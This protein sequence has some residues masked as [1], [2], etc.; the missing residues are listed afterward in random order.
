MAQTFPNY[1]SQYLNDPAKELFSD[2]T[3]NRFAQE[4]ENAFAVEYPCILSRL[5]LSVTV[6][7]SKYSIPDSITSIRRVTW[8]GYKLD[9]LPERAKRDCFQNATQIGRPFWY[10][11]NNVGLNKIQFF[12]I[13]DETIVASQVGLYDDA[14]IR[15]QVIVEYFQA[16]DFSTKIIPAY[17]RRRLLK[18]YALRGCFNIEGQGQSL[19]NAKYWKAK[20]IFLKERYGLLLAELHNK[21]RKLVVNSITASYYFPGSPILPIDRFGTSVNTGE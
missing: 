20:W 6:N 3:I 11:F 14:G 12:P 21:P 4:G 5:A 16:P 9:P 2:S 19:K 7:V 15:S 10:V 1:S 13:P 8:R 18:T 17:I